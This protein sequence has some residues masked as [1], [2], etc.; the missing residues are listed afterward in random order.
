MRFGRLTSFVLGALALAATGG[1]ASAQVK[2][3]NVSYDPTRELYVDVNKAF[4][5]LA[6]ALGRTP[7]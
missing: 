6:G 7:S 5:Q 2:L 1:T 3:L 4:A